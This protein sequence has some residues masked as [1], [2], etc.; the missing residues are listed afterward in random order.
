ML[1]FLKLTNLFYFKVI[2][3]EEISKVVP[4]LS[5]S[6]LFVLIFD[7]IFLGK[8]FTSLQYLEIFSLVVGAFLISV[9]NSKEEIR[10]SKA[11]LYIMVVNLLS[12]A[13]AIIVKY[14]LNYADF[15]TIFSYTRI[16]AIFVLIPIFYLNYPEFISIAKNKVK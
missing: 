15:W 6:S 12:S 4:L 13:G 3:I 1:D 5:F 11:F 2:K 8:I 9:K 16:G 10:L 7:A 14:L